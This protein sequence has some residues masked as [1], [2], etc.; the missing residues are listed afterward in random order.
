MAT[1]TLTTVLVIFGAVL[2]AGVVV[3]L[4]GF[5]FALVGT[6]LLAT[7]IDPATAVVL[8]I[9][10]ILGAN[11][12]LVREL[13]RDSLR[14]CARRFWPFVTAAVVGTLAGMA[15]LDRL[16]ERPITLVLGLLTLGYV[17][18]SQDRVAVPGAGAVERA[19]FTERPAAKVGLGLVSGLV[20]GATNVGVQVIAYLDSLS[21]D[22]STFVGVVAMVFL[23]ISTVRVGA[24]AALGLYGSFDVVAYS[25][26][27]VGPGLAGVAVG[28]RVRP[29]ISE[30][31]L[32]AG[33]HLLLS[34]IGLRLTA[35]GMGWL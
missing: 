32:T 6:T 13:D 10:P 16:P 28:K 21:L 23:G 11:V 35:A 31:I 27:A 9:L 33:T 30:R 3:G 18:L 25:V 1:F 5:G 20:F 14:S 24:A 2:L 22:R 19:G 26:L 8:M 29:R 12:S 34:A 15:L 4:A 7:V 17:A